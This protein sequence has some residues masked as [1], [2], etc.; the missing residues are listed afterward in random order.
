[1]Q[2][3]A[4][5]ICIATLKR[6]R[7]VKLGTLLLTIVRKQKKLS[8]NSKSAKNKIQKKIN[9]VASYKALSL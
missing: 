1:M 3:S 6:S 4:T 9:Q 7:W 5:L 2:I 8:Y